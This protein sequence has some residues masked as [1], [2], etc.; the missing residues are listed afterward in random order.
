M[1]N[2]IRMSFR[3]SSRTNQPNSRLRKCGL[4]HCHFH[5]EDTIADSFGGAATIP[6]AFNGSRPLRR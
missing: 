6:A 4:A 2:W 1:A 3:S 5:L